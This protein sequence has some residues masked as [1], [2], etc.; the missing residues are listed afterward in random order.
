MKILMITPYLPYPL[1]SGGQIRSYNLL[2]H[3]AKKHEITL[4]SFI[5]QK[6][7]TESI[8]KLKGFCQDVEVVLRRKAWSPVNILLSGFSHLPFLVAIYYSPQAKKIISDLLEK[9][10]FDLIHAETFYVMPNIPKTSVPIILVEQT[11]EYLVYDHFV[12]TLRFSPAKVLLSYDVLKIK[13]WER[14]FWQKA[15]KVVAMS[16]SDQQVMKTQ[17][18]KLDADIVPNGVDSQFFA[19]TQRKKTKQPTVLFVGNFRWLQNRE[20][21]EFLVSKVWPQIIQIL[22]RAKLWI[23]GRNPTDSVRK[24]AKNSQIIVDDKV[25]DIR[26]AYAASDVM[27]APIFGPGGTRFKILEAMA[28]GL[29]VVT[30]TTGIEGV[31]ASDKKEVIIADDA[32]RLAKS[33]TELLSDRQLSQTLAVN[34]KKLIAKHFDW[35]EISLKLDQIYREVS[36]GKAD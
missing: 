32:Q 9:E 2:K 27:L 21:V 7:E 5:R 24:L 6:E 20:A 29:P 28:S 31:P 11:V 14:H 26:W 18:T 33:T 4:V 34:A 1:L 22:P 17:V 25:G 3:L 10:K 19:Q 16:K 30:T 36:I 15:K 12:Q 23:V 13:F 35:S 8:E